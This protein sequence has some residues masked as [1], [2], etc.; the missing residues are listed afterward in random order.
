MMSEQVSLTDVWMETDRFDRTIEVFSTLFGIPPVEDDDGSLGFPA[1]GAMLWVNRSQAKAERALQSKGIV[2]IGLSVPDL[3]SR[4]RALAELGL[5]AGR[6]AQRLVIEPGEANGLSVV[7]SGDRQKGD[8]PA[9]GTARLD[10]V[11]LRVRLLKEASAR[12]AAITGVEGEQMGL[13]PIS[14]GAFSAA[15]FILGERMIELVAPTAG[16]PSPLADR[17]DSHGEGVAAL[18]LPVDDVDLVLGRLRDI[19]ARVLHQ[20]P[21]WMVHPG[22]A[23]GTLVQLTPRVEHD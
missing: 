1:R 15:R 20:D 3:A 5:D 17:L 11:A 13:H 10:H 12:W 21:H 18:A 4:S 16:V 22:D 19:D 8:L 2:A 6:N 14:G 7:L 9:N 23:G